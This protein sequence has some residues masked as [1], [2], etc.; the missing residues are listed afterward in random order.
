MALHTPKILRALFV[1]DLIKDS[2]IFFYCKILGYKSFVVITLIS[3]IVISCVFMELIL[4]LLGSKLFVLLFF[5][6]VYF[7]FYS[8]FGHIISFFS[9]SLP[10]ASSD[11]HT[12]SFLWTWWVNKWG[13]VVFYLSHQLYKEHIKEDLKTYCRVISLSFLLTLVHKIFLLLF[14]ILFW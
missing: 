14:I 3:P 11:C 1:L 6:E 5:Q 7:P 12:Q 9:S 10:L 13:T 8:C 4:L 2:W